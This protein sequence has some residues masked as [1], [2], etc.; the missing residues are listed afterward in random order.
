MGA[1]PVTAIVYTLFSALIRQR[2][3]KVGFS[4]AGAPPENRKF[5]CIAAPTGGPLSAPRSTPA[6]A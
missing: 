4:T 3:Y 5:W 6:E 1:W 2:S